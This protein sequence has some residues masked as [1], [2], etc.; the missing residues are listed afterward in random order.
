MTSGRE[1]SM[2]AHHGSVLGMICGVLLL[3]GCAASA[4][5][6]PIGVAPV[7]QGPGTTAAVRTAL[8]GR[9]VLIGLTVT[10]ADGRSAAV[11]ATGTL[12]ADAFGNLNIEF[13]ISEA[14]RKALEAVGVSSPG[15]VISTTGQAVIDAQQQR[16]TYVGDDFDKRRSGFDTDP[17]AR[18]AN[19]FA[20]ERARYYVF[21]SDGVLT[22]S[23][24]HDTGA[25]AATSR[26]KRGS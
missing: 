10:S 3:G 4:R 9:W 16:I 13:R 25:A 26:W 23:T 7:T 21:G 1:V 11:D 24:R 2:N 6:R 22:L 5:Q 17:A 19:P 15:S 20:L 12:V 18:R 14:G 8:D